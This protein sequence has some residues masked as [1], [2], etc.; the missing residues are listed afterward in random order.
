M[1]KKTIVKNGIYNAFFQFINVVYPLITSIYVSRI[2]LPEGIGKIAVAQN[3]SSYFITLSSLG[4]PIYGVR[5]ISKVKTDQKTLNKLFSNLEM[6]NIISAV[7]STII[8]I[9]LIVNLMSAKVNFVLYGLFSFHILINCINLDWFYQG[10]EEYKY[11]AVKNTIVKVMALLFIFIFVKTKQ[12]YIKYT[13]IFIASY[14]INYIFDIV[15]IRNFVRFNIYE[16]KL[17]EHLHH[18]IILGINIFL[19]TL[20]RKIDVTMLGVMTND[21][22]VGYYETAHK[23]IVIIITISGAITA[24]FLPRLSYY[25]LQNIDKFNLL[26]RK[27]VEFLSFFVFPLAAG[28][29]LL[30]PQGITIL[31]GA[32][33]EK[34][35]TTLRIFAI[36]ILIR[37]F[38]DLLCYQVLIASGNDKKMLWTYIIATLVNIF[39]NFTFIPIFLHNGAAVASVISEGLVFVIQLYFVIHIIGINLPIREIL[40]GILASL[41]MGYSIIAVTKT[42]SSIYLQFGLSILI[43]IVIYIFVNILFK[44]K[45]LI[46]ILKYLKQ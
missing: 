22:V 5:E 36:L 31:Y 20:Y 19:I 24:V 23:I 46:S 13:M 37:T 17:D 33:F 10:M 9:A 12:D 11:I 8:Y 29:F 42:T 41:L 7:I 44:N 34:S 3:L 1:S 39:L 27:G 26:I 16:L 35:I 6:I 15:Y 40:Q 21:S 30:A 45:T 14:I 2:L 32:A 18:I 25:Y 28:V 4:L 38:A 43:G